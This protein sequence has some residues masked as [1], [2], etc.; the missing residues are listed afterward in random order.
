MVHILVENLEKIPQHNLK[1][2]KLS[3]NRKLSDKSKISAHKLN[4]LQSTILENSNPNFGLR[5]GSKQGR[6][7]KSSGFMARKDTLDTLKATNLASEDKYPTFSEYTE[8][9]SKESKTGQYEY[10][11]STTFTC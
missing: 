1:M 3:R 4:Q 8:V 5:S 7:E 11:Q 2:S 9:L 10:S 6:E